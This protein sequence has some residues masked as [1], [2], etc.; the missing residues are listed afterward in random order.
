MLDLE[1]DGV[2]DAMIAQAEAIFD[3]TMPWKHTS[4]ASP[5]HLWLDITQNHFL[6]LVRWCHQT[7][8]AGTG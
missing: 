2:T 4:K 6:D 8:A 7:P 3:E 5:F 1:N